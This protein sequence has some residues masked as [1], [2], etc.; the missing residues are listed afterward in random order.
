MKPPPHS[1]PMDLE[2]TESGVA[3]SDAIS[4]GAR[5]SAVPLLLLV[6]SVGGRAATIVRK[7]R[8]LARAWCFAAMAVWCALVLLRIVA[9]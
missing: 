3:T 4:R 8:R 5:D 9:S 7:R 1:Q 2:P 6:Q